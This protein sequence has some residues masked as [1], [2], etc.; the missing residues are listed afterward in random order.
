MSETTAWVRTSGGEWHIEGPKR[1]QLAQVASAGHVKTACGE[2]LSTINITFERVTSAPARSK[3]C[4][5]CHSEAR[6]RGE[7]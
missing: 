1:G 7:G 5:E 3:R 4:D 2:S 6:R